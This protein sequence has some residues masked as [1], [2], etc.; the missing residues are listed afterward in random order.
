M[1]RAVQILLLITLAT[2]CPPR[3]Q[4]IPAQAE[5]GQDIDGTVVVLTENEAAPLAAITQVHSIQYDQTVVGMALTPKDAEN[6]AESTTR[7]GNQKFPDA[8]ERREVVPGESNLVFNWIN[9]LL[10]LCGVMAFVISSR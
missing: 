4:I 10:V 1:T 5:Q 9:V 6:A 3:V 2:S 8:E 7:A